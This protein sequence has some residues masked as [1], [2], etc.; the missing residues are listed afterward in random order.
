MKNAKWAAAICA[1][2][3]PGAARAETKIEGS[4]N[5]GGDKLFIGPHE[6]W[7]DFAPSKWPPRADWDGPAHLAEAGNARLVTSSPLW[8]GF[9]V[10]LQ[11]TFS[12]GENGDFIIE[13]TLEKLE[14]EPVQIAAWPVTQCAT[15]DAVFLPLSENSPYKNNFFW[16]GKPKAQADVK[17]LSPRLL[18]IRSAPG[19]AYKIG[20]DAPIPAIAAV[21]NGLAFLQ[22]AERQPGQYPDGAE[23][24]GLPVE[25]YNHSDTGSAHY[26]ELELLSPLKRLKIGDKISFEVRWSLHLLPSPTI[27]AGT[28]D[29]LQQLLKNG[30]PNYA[31]RAACDCEK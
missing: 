3:L 2:A 24:A 30:P 13:N 12:F 20:A 26:V 10:R 18:Q 28:L 9:G 15:P 11:R 21:K 27:G 4:K 14:G 22:R 31:P 1:L 29:S 23:G 8:P 5:W 19:A 7:L 16:F 25:F 17:A 6:R